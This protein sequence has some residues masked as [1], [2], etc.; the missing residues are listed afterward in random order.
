MSEKEFNHPAYVNMPYFVLQDIRLDPFNKM[1]F[2]F[3]WSFAVAGKKVMASNAYLATLFRVSEKHV[4]CRLKELEDMG[5]IKRYKVKYKRRIEILYVPC[6]DLE[7]DTDSPN[8]TLVPPTG[9]PS[10]NIELGTPTGVEEVHLQ[11]YPGTPTGVT[12][13]KAIAKVDNKA[14]NIALFESW[15]I[16]YPR[17][18]GRQ[19]AEKWFNKNKPNEEFVSMLIED[20][21]KR[22]AT[23]WKDKEKT[24]IPYAS[25]YL[26]ESR[27]KDEIEDSKSNKTPVI[28]SVDDPELREQLKK[29][30]I[31]REQKEEAAKEREKKEAPGIM[32][33]LKSTLAEKM[34]QHEAAIRASGLSKDEYHA[35]IVNERRVPEDNI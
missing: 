1:L 5:F 22:K 6:E 33:N 8:L 21:N 24:Y 11:V 28:R 29:Q 15:Y 31:E 32:K 9:V 20:V 18:K 7:C 4:N 2:S 26:N 12:Y 30:A 13:I 19:G 25:T 3:L 23:E 10:T 16:H 17:K 14:F 35:K 27:W 34:A